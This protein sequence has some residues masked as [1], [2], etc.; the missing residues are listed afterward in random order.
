MQSTLA[1]CTPVHCQT[2]DSTHSCAIMV[3][4]LAMMLPGVTVSM[5]RLYQ[6]VTAL[7]HWRAHGLDSNWDLSAFAATSCCCLRCGV[8]VGLCCLR[9]P[10]RYSTGLLFHLLHC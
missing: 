7:A 6:R 4:A 1:P 9:W 3:R 8:L 5:H 2:I 10:G